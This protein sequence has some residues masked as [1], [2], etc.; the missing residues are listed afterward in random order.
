MPSNRVV[1][2]RSSG[3]SVTAQEMR[4]G[5]AAIQAEASTSR[6]PS[7]RPSNGR[8]RRRP[9]RPAC[10]SSPHRHPVRHH[11]P[12]GLAGP[13]PGGAHRAAGR[14]VPA[15]G[16]RSPTS[17]RGWRRAA[18]STTRPATGSRRSTPRTA[19]S[20]LHPPLLSEG[21]ASLLPDQVRPALLWTID[22][23][24]TGEGTDVEVER[25]LVRSRAKLS[26][27][28]V[29]ADLDAGTADEPRPAR[30]VGELR[31][32]AARPPAA[33]ISL[34]LPEQEL[35]ETGDEHWDLGV[36]ATD[37]GREVERADL[38]PHR[39]GRGL[40]DGLRPRRHPPHPA[41]GGPP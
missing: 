41:A 3:D 23:D 10:R 29:Q 9:R 19:G 25:A 27:E 7:P 12:R 40:A 17:R 8:P 26:Y 28:G 18:R 21:V 4:D 39:D 37:A 2:V 35:V 22:V 32:A 34:P 14:R 36:P 31:A 30:E 15:C 6:R 5:I 33:A 24:E 1:K 11:R 13:R 20:P 16:T 38:A